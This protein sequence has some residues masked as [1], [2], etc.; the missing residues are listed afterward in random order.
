MLCLKFVAISK[1]LL[2]KV[3]GDMAGLAWADVGAPMTVPTPPMREFV[4]GVAALHKILASVLPRDQL[5]DIF[6]G[7][8][9]MVAVHVPLQYANVI[10][11]AVEAALGGSARLAPASGSHVQAAS[12]SVAFQRLSADF[13]VLCSSLR[14][15]WGADDVERETNDTPSI[16][17]VTQDAVHEETIDDGSHGGRAAGLASLSA[18]QAWVTAQ[19]DA[20]GSAAEASLPKPF[21]GL[22]ASAT[23][24]TAR[25]GEPVPSEVEPVLKS[26]NS[27]DQED[28]D[29]V[30]ASSLSVAESDALQ[31]QACDIAIEHAA[32]DDQ[33][34][35]Q[36]TSHMSQQGDSLSARAL[37]PE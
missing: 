27:E 12:R 23:S 10:S 16:A 6:A 4:K 7:I 33:H 36:A 22:L 30:G 26:S 37:V 1:D 19:F 20:A 24:E 31:Q 11:R 28:V 2:T 9:A 5:A 17:Q 29:G 15:L 13:N 14:Q 3:C 25:A 34:T 8:D 35:L 32:E 18:L 21:S